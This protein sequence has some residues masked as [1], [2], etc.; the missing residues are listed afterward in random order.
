MSQSSDRQHD[1]KTNVYSASNHANAQTDL[2]YIQGQ[3]VYPSLAF[4][5]S[6][7]PLAPTVD[8]TPIDILDTTLKYGTEMLGLEMD[9]QTNKQCATCHDQVYLQNV[10]TLQNLSRISCTAGKRCRDT[11]LDSTVSLRTFGVITKIFAAACL[12]C[13]YVRTP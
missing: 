3:L 11:T 13:T 7:N 10:M 2:D 12:V 1:T 4:P 8:P 9:D 6:V 5:V